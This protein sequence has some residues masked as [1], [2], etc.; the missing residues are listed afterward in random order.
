MAT[1]ILFVD[2]DGTLIEEPEDFQI[3][4]Y[5]KLRFV[6]G[7]IPALLKLRDAGYEFVIVSNQD[8]LGS[9][10]YP[11]EAFD[12]PQGLMMQVFESQGITFREVLVADPALVRVLRACQAPYPVPTPCAQLATAGLSPAALARTAAGVEQVRSERARLATALAAMDGVTRVYPSDGNYLLVRLADAGTAFERLLA[13][14]VVVRDQRAAPQLHDALRIT[15]GTPEE[16]DR[17]LAALGAK[18]TIA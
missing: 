6:P 7:V 3:D 10:A 14:G 2:R 18:E 9:D 8:G 1:K 4:A 17:V 12:G 11:Q 13:A 5:H 15:V 16:N